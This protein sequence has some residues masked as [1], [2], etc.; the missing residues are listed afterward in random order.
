MEALRKWIRKVMTG[1]AAFL[2]AAW[3]TLGSIDLSH[4]MMLPFGGPYSYM[5]T[6]QGMRVAM[7]D[8][9]HLART[10]E[11]VREERIR[12]TAARER[13]NEQEKAAS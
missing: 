9:E 12:Q 10:E 3:Q 1:V 7:E 6:Q 4:H 11:E 13:A 5:W 2:L 8:P